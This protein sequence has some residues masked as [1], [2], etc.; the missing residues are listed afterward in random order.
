MENLKKR[1][2]HLLHLSKGKLRFL[3]VR[4]LIHWKLNF[5]LAEVVGLYNKHNYNI[6]MYIITMSVACLKHWLGFGILYFWA[7]TFFS[8]ITAFVGKAAYQTLERWFFCVD[9]YYSFCFNS[10]YQECRSCQE[11][12]TDWKTQKSTVGTEVG[13]NCSTIEY[14]TET[15]PLVYL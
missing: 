6:I 8:L 1:G 15:L 9:F 10:A 5:S 2:V 7:N 4:V 3:Y 14:C 12:Q 11:R 13:L